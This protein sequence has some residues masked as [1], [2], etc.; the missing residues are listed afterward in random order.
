MYYNVYTSF[1]D[2][3]YVYIYKLGVH[4]LADDLKKKNLTKNVCM[5]IRDHM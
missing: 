1:W 3:L 5:N 2:T 4:K